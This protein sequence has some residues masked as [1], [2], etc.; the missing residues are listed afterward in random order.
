MK[1]AQKDLLKTHF[2]MSLGWLVRQRKVSA[3]PL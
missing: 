2:G 1:K 3:M